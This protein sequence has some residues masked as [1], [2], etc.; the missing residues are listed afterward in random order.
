[1]P[2][3]IVFVVEEKPHDTY[4]RRAQ[5]MHTGAAGLQRVAKKNLQRA[6]CVWRL[7]FLPRLSSH[8]FFASERLLIRREGNDLVHQI[9]ITLEQALKGLFALV[10]PV[11]H[12]SLPLA[13][14]HRRPPPHSGGVVGIPRN[15][16]LGSAATACC[17]DTTLLRSCAAAQSISKSVCRSLSLAPCPPQTLDARQLRVQ[18]EEM[19]HPGMVK[20][21]KGE[22]MPNPK[23]RAPHRHLFCRKNAL[24]RPQSALHARR[25]ELLGRVVMYAFSISRVSATCPL[26]LLTVPVALLQEPGKYGDMRIEFDVRFPLNL[27]Q[28]QR[29]ALRA[30]L[31]SF[32]CLYDTAPRS[33]P[34]VF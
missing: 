16:L 1:M 28:E 17:A 6:G 21:L 11:S 20:V 10:L 26:L 34:K 15:P 23:A 22:G 29:D 19:V 3:D 2:A 8:L 25:A 27:S 12:P 7:L 31:Q 33:G 14:A 32:R 9:P 13:A 30:Q 5:R 4:K 18:V 24:G